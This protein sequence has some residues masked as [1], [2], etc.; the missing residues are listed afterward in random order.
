MSLQDGVDESFVAGGSSDDAVVA[1]EVKW[2]FLEAALTTREAELERVRVTADARSGFVDLLKNLLEQEN[3][4]FEK[5]MEDL[6]A[7]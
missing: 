4:S 1:S 6:A 3:A 5:I 2:A 7:R